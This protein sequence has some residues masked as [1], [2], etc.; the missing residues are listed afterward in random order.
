[1]VLVIFLLFS[2]PKIIIRSSKS[3]ITNIKTS[4]EDLIFIS[5]LSSKAREFYNYERVKNS[6][7]IIPENII[8]DWVVNEKVTFFL[9]LAGLAISIL[10]TIEELVLSI[11]LEIWEHSQKKEKKEKKETAAN[12]DPQSTKL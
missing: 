10:Y 6:G 7:I 1:M 3:L 12:I 9:I 4:L 8:E 2:I 5:I 11:I